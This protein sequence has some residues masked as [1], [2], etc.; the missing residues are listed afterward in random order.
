[1][2]PKW[3]A[4]L[5]VSADRGAVFAIVETMLGGDG[6]QPAQAPDRPLSRI[7]MRVVGG[8]LRPRRQGARGGVRRPSPKRRLPWKRTADEI[9]YDVI[10]RREQFGRGCQVPAG[11]G[12]PRRRDSDR[13]DARGA[14]SA[15]PGAGAHARQGSARSRCALEPADA[16]RGYARARD[17]H[18]RAR[19]AH[20]HA[21]RGCRV[22]G[23]PGGGAQRHR[24]RRASG[25]NAT[26][27]G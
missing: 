19:R 8:F 1:M 11:G 17:A 5:L 26:A 7:E 20:G 27:S 16:E 22:R 24:A 9:D 25:S 23:R 13:R 21:G 6:S 2:P 18:R 15:A 12:Q 3:N 4:R 10:G 14:Q